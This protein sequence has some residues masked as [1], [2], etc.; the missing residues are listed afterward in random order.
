MANDREI[1][2]STDHAL[3][4]RVYDYA[5]QA[6]PSMATVSVFDNT[7]TAVVD[8]ASASIDADGT[9]T[10]TIAG[11]DI[12]SPRSN[13]RVEL[14]YVISGS[15]HYINEL[16]DVVK[17]PIQNITTDDDLY[18][19]VP[20]LRDK[21]T[22]YEGSAT[23][24]LTGSPNTLRST[25]IRYITEALQGGYVEIYLDTEMLKRLVVSVD[26]SN[27]DI[28]FDPAHTT[29]IPQG[30]RYALRGS[31]TNAIKA[32]FE[33][34][35][36]VVRNRA[37]TASA[38]ID[39]YVIQRAVVYRAIAIIAAAYVEETDDKYDLR[40]TMYTDMYN[41]EIARLVEPIDTNGDGNI[42]D[43]E[44]DNRASIYSVGL[45]L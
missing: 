29:D 18:V 15:T 10:Y 14:A 19:Y 30:T 20:E 44:D 40:R 32:A 17:T 27:G 35:R 24:E 34:V 22:T 31:Y 8:G 2:E 36:Q 13:Y 11:T 39:S 12:P 23:S 43:Y 3:E 41:S 5:I 38:Y 37:K 4:W 33:E 16:F 1:R 7:G 25:N 9:I 6:V 28:V 45:T 26:K 42:S 21:L